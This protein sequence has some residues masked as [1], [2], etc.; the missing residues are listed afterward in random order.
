M[1]RHPAC[2]GSRWQR[3]TAPS[4]QAWANLGLPCALCNRPIDYTL[5]AR[6]RWGLTVDHRVPLWEGGHPVDPANWQPAHRSCNSS[7]GAREGNAL[8]RPNRPR[9]RLITNLTLR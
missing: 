4:R 5:D 2:S 1:P 9:P 7:R 6:S 3:I 8:R